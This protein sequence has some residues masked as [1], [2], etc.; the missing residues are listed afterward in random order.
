V[1]VV[2][3]NPTVATGQSITLS[4]QM[5]PG[6]GTCT[7]QTA[8]YEIFTN[9]SLAYGDNEFILPDSGG[10]RSGMWVHKIQTGVGQEQWQQGVVLVAPS[11]DP[12]K[13]ARVNWTFHPS[14]VKVNVQGDAGMGT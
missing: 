2:V 6:G 8:S 10:L 7:D 9:L 11:T 3:H 12:T 13:H 5:I 1:K 14:V 4:G